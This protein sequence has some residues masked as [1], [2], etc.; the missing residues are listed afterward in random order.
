MK[1]AEF[2]ANHVILSVGS[3]PADP[4]RSGQRSGRGSDSHGSRGSDNTAVAA[5]VAFQIQMDTD[6]LTCPQRHP[7]ISRVSEH[8]TR[9]GEAVFLSQLNQHTKIRMPI[10]G[11]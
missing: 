5:A 8:I 9:G 7:V 3:D 4:G 6:S 11:N 10:R 1:S 2:F